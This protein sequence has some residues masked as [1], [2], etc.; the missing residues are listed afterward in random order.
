MTETGLIIGQAVFLLL[1]YLFIA[2]VVR[3]STRALKSAELEITPPRQPEPEPSRR[4][5]MAASRTEVVGTPGVLAAAVVGTGAASRAGTAPPLSEAA[6]PEVVRAAATADPHLVVTRSSSLP[7]DA[8][9][10]VA[11]GV[12]IGRSRTSRIPV[13]D[14]FISHTHARVFRRG[15]FWFVED[16]GSLNG[17]FVNGR[18]ISG[19]QQLHLRDEIR[20]GETVLRWEE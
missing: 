9:Y 2:F 18:R 17:T 5:G 15:H 6:R 12:T 3:A 20:A 13:T 10:D 8:V 7:V 4:S 14:Q 1:L 19:E 11:G 16:L